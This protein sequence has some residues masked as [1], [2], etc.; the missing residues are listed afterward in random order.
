[1]D[2]LS[3]ARPTVQC[4][5]VFPAL[6]VAPQWPPDAKQGRLD[7][8]WSSPCGEEDVDVCNDQMMSYLHHIYTC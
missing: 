5:Q 2:M 4:L 8:V 1:M 3:T 6:S 7:L